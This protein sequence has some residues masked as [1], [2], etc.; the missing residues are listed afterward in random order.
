M[1]KDKEITIRSSP[2]ENLTYVAAVGD[3]P[4]ALEIRY[5]DENVWLTQKMMVQLYDVTV[6][7]GEAYTNWEGYRRSKVYKFLRLHDSGEQAPK[8]YSTRRG[9]HLL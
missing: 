8:S 3:Q 5:E 2:E 6:A 7:K 4:D 9:G 1:K